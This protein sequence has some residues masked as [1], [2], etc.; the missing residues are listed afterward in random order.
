MNVE[1]IIQSVQNRGSELLRTFAH[2]PGFAPRLDIDARTH[3]AKLIVKYADRQAERTIATQIVCN[4]P[5]KQA[6][7]AL[8]L[9]YQ[10][11]VKELVK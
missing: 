10:D 6:S 4:A 9:V 7:D 8:A 1:W 3:Q 2:Q 11:C 5:K